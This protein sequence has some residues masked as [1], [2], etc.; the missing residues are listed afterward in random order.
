M[1]CNSHIYAQIYFNQAEY[2]SIKFLGCWAYRIL[3]SG[4]TLSSQPYRLFYRR[5]CRLTPRAIPDMEHLPST[6]SQF[7]PPFPVDR[8]F[9]LDLLINNASTRPVTCPVVH[10]PAYETLHMVRAS[11]CA[12]RGQRKSGRAGGISDAAKTVRDCLRKVS[13]AL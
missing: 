9:D 5:Q 8:S 6:Y 13:P 10:C 7:R 2:S 4:P 11:I 12:L 3:Q 1:T